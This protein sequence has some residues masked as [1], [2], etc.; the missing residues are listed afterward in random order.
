MKIGS[1]WKMK[2]KNGKEFISVVI[3]L[4]IIGKVKFVLF[5]NDNKQSDN[6][7]DYDVVWTP[8]RKKEQTS[9]KAFDDDVPF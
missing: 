6:H 2:S 4:P 8:E 1:A 9:N 7:P 5:D 3:E